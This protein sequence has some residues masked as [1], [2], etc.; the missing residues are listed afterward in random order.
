RVGLVAVGVRVVA[1]AWEHDARLAG[2]EV[3]NLE[4]GAFFEIGDLAAVRREARLEFLGLALDHRGLLEAGS[5]EAIR[6]VLVREV[7]AM[8]LATLPALG[9]IEQAAA[10]GREAHRSLLL[11]RVRDAPRVAVLRRSDEDLA[12]R[13][14]RDLTAVRRDVELGD[15]R[16]NVGGL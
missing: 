12:A 15:L 7:D 14:E 1:I 13:H 8:D 3:E 4:R 6:L 9:G 11:G 2:L 5:I 10:V 16:R